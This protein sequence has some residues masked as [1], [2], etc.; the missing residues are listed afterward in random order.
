MLDPVIWDWHYGMWT[1]GHMAGAG[2]L[3]ALLWM[4]LLISLPIYL[5]YWLATQLQTEDSVPRALL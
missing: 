5:V 1:D 2:M 3:F 4:V